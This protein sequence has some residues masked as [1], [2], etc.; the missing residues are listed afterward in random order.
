MRTTD[1]AVPADAVRPAPARPGAGQWVGYLFG[2]GLPGELSGWVLRDTTGPAWLVRHAVRWLTRIAPFAIAVL[3][4]PV[5]SFGMR[6]AVVVS[7]L[8]LGLFF[9]FAF[10]AETADRRL[11]KAGYPPG[12]GEQVRRAARARG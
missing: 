10:V 11:V 1:K 9:S 2:A 4:V 7:A 3:V 8:L 6:V 5:D 12:Y